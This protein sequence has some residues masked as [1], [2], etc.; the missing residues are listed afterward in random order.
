[1]LR[2]LHRQVEQAAAKAGPLQLDSVWEDILDGLRELGVEVR[3]AGRQVKA[4][5]ASCSS[6]RF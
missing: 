4:R 5:C 6:R 2:Q 1:M 3:E